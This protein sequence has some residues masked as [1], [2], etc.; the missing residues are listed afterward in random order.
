MIFIPIKN[1]KA[2]HTVQLVE[3]VSIKHRTLSTALTGPGGAC[4]YHYPSTGVVEAGQ[5]EAKSY[6][7]L[8]KEFE[9]NL[10]CIRPYT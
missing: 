6:P 8:C 2:G 4:R 1:S 5:S 3:S 10:G 7:Q 9:T